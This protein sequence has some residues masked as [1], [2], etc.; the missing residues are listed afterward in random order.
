MESKG[1]FVEAGGVLIDDDVP[2]SV[3]GDGGAVVYVDDEGGVGLGRDERRCCGDEKC[4][5]QKTG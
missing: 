2:V 3:E 1:A 4:G 5:E